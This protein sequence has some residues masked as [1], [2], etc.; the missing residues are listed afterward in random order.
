MHMHPIYIMCHGFAWLDARC[1]PKPLYH[2]S[3]S[4]GHRRKKHD[5]RLMDQD[6]DKERLLTN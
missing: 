3:S 5:K 2:S 4:A 6:K 1:L